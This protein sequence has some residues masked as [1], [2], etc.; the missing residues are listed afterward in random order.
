M[1][2]KSAAKDYDFDG[3][4][5]SA[6]QKGASDVHLQTGSRPCFRINGDVIPTDAP[7]VS[8]ETIEAIKSLLMDDVAVRRIEEAGCVDRSYTLHDAG[9]V[10]GRLRVSFGRCLEGHKIVGRLIPI[11]V[12]SIEGLQLPEVFTHIADEQH[13]MVII[14][15]VTGSGKST[16]LAAMIERINTRRKAHIVTIEDP[17]EFVH[18]P[19]QSIFTHREI[20]TNVPSF[21][22]GLRTVLRQ[23]PDVILVGEMRDL[24]SIR[25]GLVAAETGHLVFTTVH[26]EAVSDIPERIISMFPEREQEQARFQIA[27]VGLAFIAQQL[28]KRRDGQGRLAAFEILVLNGAAR[29]LIRTKKSHQLDS[30]MQTQVRSGC[31]TMTRDLIEMHK[32]G[33][34]DRETLVASAPNKERARK[35]AMEEVHVDTAEPTFFDPEHGSRL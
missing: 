22:E 34:I 14:A 32:A 25:Y 20:G 1:L 29:N 33:L 24:E 8:H 10:V 30:V 12:P 5:L 3:L 26:S 6:L 23:D 13:G 18:L 15:G 11:E 21:A 28:V 17:V 16:T 19:R 35:Y 4:V 9:H 27:D 2:R 7:V 31:T